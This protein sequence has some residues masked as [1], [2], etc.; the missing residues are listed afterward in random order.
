MNFFHA[1]KPTSPESALRRVRFVLS[2]RQH[3]DVIGHT[4][5][6]LDCVGAVFICGVIVAMMTS[7]QNQ[8]VTVR[9]CF[10]SHSDC[11][12]DL[13]DNDPDQVTEPFI[14]DVG[15]RLDSGVEA[16]HFDHHVPALPL[17]MS[18]QVSAVSLTA[19]YFREHWGGGSIPIPD[20]VISLIHR[21][22]GA[23]FNDEDVKKSRYG[24]L[25]AWFNALR[26]A[27]MPDIDRLIAF[28]DL[29]RD[30]ITHESLSAALEMEPRATMIARQ[31]VEYDGIADVA[32]EVLAREGTY[33]STNNNIVYY[34]P[35]SALPRGLTF[36]LK[37]LFPIVA[38]GPGPVG[39][40]GISTLPDVA[41]ATQIIPD[42]IA[43]LGQQQP[44]EMSAKIISELRGWHLEPFFGGRSPKGG[45]IPP[46][47]QGLTMY[48]IAKIID[49][50]LIA[51]R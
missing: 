40:R 46:L 44:S 18:R 34:A 26:N 15:K 24:G 23:G 7:D 41:P 37:S 50:F 14:V 25:H 1:P 19:G 4:D 22:D 8:I 35:D 47:A 30:A 2:D 17:D 20:E 32:A 13:I 42:L 49:E 21:G 6:D 51:I 31:R 45:E 28:V 29:V 5:A 38:Y 3:A 39:E 12:C 27:R 36:A 33:V 10:L 11:D 43:W 16:R 9:V 48:D